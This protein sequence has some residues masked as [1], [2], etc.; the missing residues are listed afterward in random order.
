MSVVQ[1]S[2]PVRAQSSCSFTALR[3]TRIGSG[4]MVS[5]SLILT[6][7]WARMATMERRRCWL[8]PIRPVTPF[9]AMPTRWVVILSTVGRSSGFVGAL[10]PRALGEGRDVDS[11]ARKGAG[12]LLAPVRHL[13]RRAVHVN[14]LRRLLA[15]VGE[16]VEDAGGDVDGLAGAQRLALLAQAHLRGPLH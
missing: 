10:R 14:H 11:G 1:R 12:E 7:P 2:M 6:P 13:P 4:T 8:V 5:L 3:P 15:D 9:M 16:L